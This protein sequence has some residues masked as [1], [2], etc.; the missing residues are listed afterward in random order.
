MVL[1]SK[2]N[3][4]LFF[5]ST[6]LFIVCFWILHFALTKRDTGRFY[7]RSTFIYLHMLIQ[8]SS[9]ISG[10]RAP[11][12]TTNSFLKAYP[13]YDFLI[14]SPLAWKRLPGHTWGWTHLPSVCT[15]LK[16]TSMWEVCQSLIMIR[17]PMK[18]QSENSN[19]VMIWNHELFWLICQDHRVVV[20]VEV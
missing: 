13:I 19:R 7:W 20:V 8:K 17:V 14:F 11:G 6:W 12:S 9:E 4:L 10:Y 15:L 5:H 3:F 16:L 1:S 18:C 2:R